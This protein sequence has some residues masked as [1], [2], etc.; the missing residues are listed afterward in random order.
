MQTHLQLPE[1][2][3]VKLKLTL[4]A[5]GSVKEVHVLDSESTLNRVY[6]ETHLKELPFPPIEQGVLKKDEE[7]FHIT[8]CNAT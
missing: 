6:L 3:K 8:F 2:G 7:T 1:F 4:G 5:D